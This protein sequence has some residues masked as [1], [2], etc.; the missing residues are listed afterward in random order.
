MLFEETVAVYC[1]NHM[2]HT[3]TLCGKNAEFKYFRAVVHVV[4]TGFY[5]V[6]ISEQQRISYVITYGKEESKWHCHNAFYKFTYMVHCKMPW[7]LFMCDLFNGVDICTDCMASN[8]RV[9]SWP[10]LWIE[11]VQNEASWPNLGYRPHSY[12]EELMETTKTSFLGRA[13]DFLPYCCQLKVW[14]THK[15]VLVIQY[16][17]MF[18]RRKWS[19]HFSS[20]LLNKHRVLQ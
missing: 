11:K 14:R 2:E 10:L 8:D 4:T 12:E 16:M 3:N 20:R 15:S 19:P 9:T 5:R 7:F 6:K 13:L 18:R 17:E 1:E